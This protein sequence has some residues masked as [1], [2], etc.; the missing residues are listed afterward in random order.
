[1]STFEQMKKYL[2][3]HEDCDLCYDSPYS[4]YINDLYFQA[5]EMLSEQFPELFIEPSIRGGEGGM[6]ATYVIEGKTY[7]TDWD[8]RG[9]C[10]S[11][12]G[13]VDDCTSE[14]QLIECIKNF[15]ENHLSDAEP[16]EYDDEECDEED[17]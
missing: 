14:K 3:K 8:F 17:E 2:N 6:F 10:Y 4:D 9:E 7:H 13:F 15:L 5:Q 12:E 16:Y 1:M 11:I